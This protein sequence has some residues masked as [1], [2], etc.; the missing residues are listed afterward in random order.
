M[1]CN[2]EKKNKQENNTQH[3][4]LNDYKF[5]DYRLTQ[6]ENKIEKGLDN[7]EQEQRSYQLEVMKTLHSLQ[8][9]QNK[10]SENMAKLQQRIDTLEHNERHLDNLKDTARTNTTNIGAV[11]HRVDVVQKILFAVG[12]A[13]VSALFAAA[14]SIVQLLLLR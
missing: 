1:M 3:T 6:L 12:G 2:N 7:I 10:T 9:G 5:I 4:L 13:A 14:F 8:E 11:N